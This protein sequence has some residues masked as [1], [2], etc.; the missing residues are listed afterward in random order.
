MKDV[1]NLH[2]AQLEAELFEREFKRR[3]YKRTQC[4]SDAKRA[5]PQE[6]LRHD[7][8]SNRVVASKGT[9]FKGEAI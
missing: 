6:W 2:T 8:Q 5:L 4:R 9:K 3:N 1:S 7:S